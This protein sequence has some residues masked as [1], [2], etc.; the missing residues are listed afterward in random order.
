MLKIYNKFNKI[1]TT[2]LYLYIT[3]LL[4]INLLCS[5]AYRIYYDKYIY[6]SK[7]NLNKIK[8][9]DISKISPYDFSNNYDFTIYNSEIAYRSKSEIAE[10][11]NS[12][13]LELDKLV[14]FRPHRQILHEIIVQTITRYRYSTDVQM[15]A[16]IEECKNHIIDLPDTQELIKS[17]E[18]T[19]V[20]IYSKLNKNKSKIILSQNIGQTIVL[21]PD[22]KLKLEQDYLYNIYADSKIKEYVGNYYNNFFKKYP[23]K[24][25]VYYNNLKPKS[26]M[27]NGG[28]GSGKSSAL[29]MIRK[30]L[31]FIGDEWQDY[32]KID[33]DNIKNIL[34]KLSDKN[35]LYHNQLVQPEIN[36]LNK[37]LLEPRIHDLLNTKKIQF[38]IWDIVISSMDK[39]EWGLLNNGS[40]IIYLIHTDVNKAI[41]RS[42]LRS[43]K[44][45]RFEPVEVLLEWHKN[46][47]LTLPSIINKFANKNV[48][49]FLLENNSNDYNMTKLMEVFCLDKNI[50]I[51]NQNGILDFA[52]KS[53]INIKAKNNVQLYNNTNYNNNFIWEYFKPIIESGYRI[54]FI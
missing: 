49:V 2:K 3:L 16:Q 20:N 21:S 29:N 36:I 18:A 7:N 37:K 30:K 54:E 52:K 17:L 27:I 12:T 42:Y 43:F 38:I 6:I 28:P 4:I 24:K 5:L 23:E 15:L 32:V 45:N 40:V 9:W 41:N 50:I 48:Q 25:I 11:Y 13:K 44:I 47:A 39:I 22:I 46:S 34:L 31:E 35:K 53:F 14:S 10:L 33:K 8:V 51:L 26:I 19:R 1:F